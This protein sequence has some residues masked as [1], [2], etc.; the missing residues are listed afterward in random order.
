MVDA[1]DLVVDDAFDQVED[2]PSGQCP[3]EKGFP[4]AYSWWRI[5]LQSAQTPAATRAQAARWNSPSASMLLSM[6]FSVVRAQRS[7]LESM[8]C[9]WKIWWNRMPS[10]ESAEAEAEEDARRCHGRDRGRAYAVRVPGCDWGGSGFH[11]Q[12]VS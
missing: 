7:V 12:F 3:A 9:H 1:E 10:N 11:G 2:A 6:P 5:P 4:L 8:L